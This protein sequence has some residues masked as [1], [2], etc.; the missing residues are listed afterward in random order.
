MKTL[1]NPYSIELIKHFSPVHNIFTEMSNSADIRELEG[2]M[3]WDF[4]YLHGS[5]HTAKLDGIYVSRRLDFDDPSPLSDHIHMLAKL[6]WLT[7]GHPP[8]GVLQND[9]LEISDVEFEA[10]TNE[11]IANYN[12]K[13]AEILNIFESSSCNKTFMSFQEKDGLYISFASVSLQGRNA[14]LHSAF[15]SVD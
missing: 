9:D 7:I 12:E 10:K 11:I 14:I 5:G 8:Y 4:K 2:G 3:V 1:K 6:I 13:A 15:W